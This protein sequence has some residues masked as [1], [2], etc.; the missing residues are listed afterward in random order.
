MT[1]NF[2]L[3]IIIDFILMS[4][5]YLKI[6][7]LDRWVSGLQIQYALQSLQVKCT[8]TVSIKLLALLSVEG[9]Q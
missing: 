1:L 9:I 7:S 4:L 3:Y 6:V 5:H 2:N 8:V